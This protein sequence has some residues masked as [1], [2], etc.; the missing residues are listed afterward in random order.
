MNFSTFSD[1][2][3]H[4]AHWYLYVLGFCKEE[5][6]DGVAEMGYNVDSRWVH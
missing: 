3:S 2:L 4:A 1:F 5:E 6:S